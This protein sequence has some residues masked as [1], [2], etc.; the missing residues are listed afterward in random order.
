MTVILGDLGHEVLR[1]LAVSRDDT[2]ETGEGV[3]LA[4]Q[5][6]KAGP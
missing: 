3:F 1:A 2:H 6:A 4:K 5:T